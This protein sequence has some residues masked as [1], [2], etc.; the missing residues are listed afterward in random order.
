MSETALL[1]RLLIA[2]SNA[3]A[4]LFRNHVGLA[5]QGKAIRV[6]RACSVRV[7][8]G[9]VVIEKARL[10]KAG[11]CVGSSDAIGWTSRVVTPDM[12]GKR[13]AV[14]TAAEAKSEQG[15]LTPEQDNFL[16]QVEHAGGI[17]LEC[18]DVD[19]SVDALNKWEGKP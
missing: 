15:R 7:E 4:R 12:V 2:F 18:R 1:H 8:P 13:I 10:V 5:Y 16:K 3:G 19:S 14:F 6:T 17:A 9:D 11:L